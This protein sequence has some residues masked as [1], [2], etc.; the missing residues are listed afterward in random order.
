[1]EAHNSQVSAKIFQSTPSARRATQLPSATGS[2]IANFNPRPPRGGRLLVKPC[3]TVD[4]VFQSTPSARRATACKGGE[5]VAKDISI[6]ALREEGDSTARTAPAPAMRFQ[7]TPS[8]RRA[9]RSFCTSALGS[10]YFNPR[11]PR[12]GRPCHGTCEEYKAEFQST[13]SARRAT[14]AARETAKENRISIHALR[15]EGDEVHLCGC[16]CQMISIHAL[17]EE[18]D[19]EGI[20][21]VFFD[22]DFNP[23]P[24]RGGRPRA[25]LHRQHQTTFQSTPSAR[26]ATLCQSVEPHFSLYFNPRPPRGGRRVYQRW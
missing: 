16:L 9:T 5:Q 13:P 24:P 1:M 23:R 25:L 26:R 7:S 22:G 12:G 4:A 20:V 14:E 15:E 3:I 17:R 21:N 6:H 19:F 18:G 8:A 10:P 2:R 11:P